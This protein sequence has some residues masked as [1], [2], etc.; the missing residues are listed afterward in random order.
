[1]P[2]CASHKS[3][4][5]QESLRGGVPP[6]NG[7][8]GGRHP[9]IRVLPPLGKSRP[10]SIHR[11]PLCLVQQLTAPYPEL[12]LGYIYTAILILKLLYYF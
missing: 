1:M 3:N 2:H 10:T 7:G 11:L 4:L 12:T 6:L 8:S 9:Q 5:T